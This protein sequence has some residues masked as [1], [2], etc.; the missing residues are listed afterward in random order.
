MFSIF[1]A[2][3]L[4]LAWIGIYGVL[5][6]A[7]A[8]RTQ[9]LGIRVA[10]GAG[11]RDVFRLVLGHGAR[12][13][14]LGVVAGLVGAFGVTRVVRSVLYN[15]GATD[16]LSFVGAALFLAAAALLASYLP[17]RRATAVDP[18]VALRTE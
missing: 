18:L 11:R 5:S 1:G 17:A 12:L 16:P 7:V 6:Y 9:E 4:F 2:V 10:L 15:V 14:G 13:A 8:Q 3:A